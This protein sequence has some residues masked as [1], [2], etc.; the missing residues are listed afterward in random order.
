VSPEPQFFDYAR[1]LLVLG[2]VLLLAYI[3][4]RYLLPK[5]TGMR[6]ASSGPMQVVAR[7]TL[8]PG[9]NLYVIKAGS[10]C[11]LV[12]TSAA[13]I[14]Y[15]APVDAEAVQT[16]PGADAKPAD[17]SRLLETMRGAKE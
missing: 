14:H 5:V 6:Q 10:A 7:M 2:G 4:L 16:A 11:F 8:E 17:F 9:K 3:A 12:G 1:L 13:G 15:L